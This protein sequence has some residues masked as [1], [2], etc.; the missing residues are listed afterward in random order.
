M[1]LRVPLKIYN[2]QS[3]MVVQNLVL[4]ALLAYDFFFLFNVYNWHVTHGDAEGHKVLYRPQYFLKDYLTE[5]DVKDSV[6]LYAHILTAILP[7]VLSPL[8]VWKAMRS[9]SLKAHRWMGRVCLSLSLVTGIPTLYLALRVIDNG[10]LE[11]ALVVFA[12]LLWI[13]SAVL[14]WHYA[15]TKQIARHRRWGVR[16]VVLTHSVPVWSRIVGSL[17][18]ISWSRPSA[19]SIDP[20]ASSHARLFPWMTWITVATLLP[21]CEAL[22]YLETPVPMTL[23]ERYSEIVEIFARKKQP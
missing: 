3:C 14:T 19:W 23:S 13:L 10:M 7:L 20:P 6:A 4:A 21:L 9:R 1:S 5:F 2:H 15:W 22:V 8:Q 16:F 17:L 12:G 18:Y 11:H